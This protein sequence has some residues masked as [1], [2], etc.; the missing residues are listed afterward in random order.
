MAPTEAANDEVEQD[1][2]DG[3]FPPCIL[4][5]IYYI[6]PGEKRTKRGVI[7]VDLN[8]ADVPMSFSCGI[9]EEMSEFD[10]C[11]V[12]FYKFCAVV[13]VITFT[14]QYLL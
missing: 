2:I 1:I 3:R 11:V 4:Y 13:V 14:R 9:Q 7:V 10:C 12:C 5:K 6:S 8:G